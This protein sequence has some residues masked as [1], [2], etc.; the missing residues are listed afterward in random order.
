VVNLKERS[1]TDQETGTSANN[2]VNR[3]R[4]NIIDRNDRQG[5]R[6]YDKRGNEVKQKNIRGRNDDKKNNDRGNGDEKRN[7]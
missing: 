4:S 6:N 7:K 1:V 3:G 2:Q 5:D